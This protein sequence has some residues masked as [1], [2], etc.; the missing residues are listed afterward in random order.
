M[1]TDTHNQNLSQYFS[2][3]NDFIHSARLRNGKILIHCLA[4]ISR[5]VTIVV[6]YIMSVT[7]YGWKDSLKVVRAGRNVANP[8]LSFQSQ[9]QD[10]ETFR[11]VE[12]RKRM[13]ERFPS[14]QLEIGDLQ[15]CLIALQ[16]YEHLL[17]SHAICTANCGV[18]DRCPTGKYYFLPHKIYILVCG[19]ISFRFW[20][21][22]IN[23]NRKSMNIILI[24]LLFSAFFSA[25]TFW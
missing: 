12:E 18:G 19:I 25:F 7:D 10:F 21:I 20:H 1:A 6:A 4:G 9:L 2:V 11:L 13:R 22:F 3:C 8:N 23:I 24:R 15:M 5:S 14:R 17:I 16:K